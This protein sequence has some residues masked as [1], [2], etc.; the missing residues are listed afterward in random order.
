VTVSFAFITTVHTAPAADEHPL[1]EVNVFVPEVAGAVS[2]TLAPALYVSESPVV[3]DARPLLSFGDTV[4]PT[5][6]AGFVE[7]T[8][9][10]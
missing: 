1:H 2:E 8:V 4:M 7:F 3:P 9:R 10:L 5:P 6:L